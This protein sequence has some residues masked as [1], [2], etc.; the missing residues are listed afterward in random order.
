MPQLVLDQVRKFYGT[1]EAVRPTNLV[2]EDGEFAILVGPSGCGKSTIL[3]MIAGLEDP[4]GGEIRLNGRD[5]TASASK[6]RDVAMVFQDYALYPHLSVFDNMAFSMII[7]KRP[8][9]EMERRVGEAAE[10]LGLSKLLDRRPGALSGGQRQRVALGRAM[11]RKPSLFLFDEPLS[12][13]DAALRGGM[14]AELSKLHHR[15]NATSVFVTH[16]Q[17]EAMTMGSKIVVLKDGVIQQVGRPLDIYNS[18]AN[19]FVASF[20]GSPKMNMFDARIIARDGGLWVDAGAFSLRIPPALE[21]SY[22]GNEGSAVRF[23]IRPSDIS[24]RPHDGADSNVLSAE[25][26][27]VE[28]LGQ[29][30]HL[31]CRVG[32]AEFIAVVAAQNMPLVG[33]RLDLHVDMT[34]MHLFAVEGLGVRLGQ[35]TSAATVAA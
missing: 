26:E 22:A 10:I 14:R 6:E 25:V 35:W 31:Y 7:Q 17:V 2:I 19:A 11:V 12:N 20:I 3:R 27:V 8:R 15:L 18:P 23:G 28:P 32:D 30:T 34:R 13:L 9:E 4:S 24:D 21:A 1:V 5:I 29:E 33:S 16:D